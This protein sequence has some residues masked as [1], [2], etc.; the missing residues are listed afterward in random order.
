MTQF[1]DY[2]VGN[3]SENKGG[4]MTYQAHED[5]EGFE[6]LYE[7]RQRGEM[8]LEEWAAHLNPYDPDE[9]P[10]SYGP[11]REGFLLGVCWFL[12]H[13]IERHKRD[14][15]DIEADIEAIKQKHAPGIDLSRIDDFVRVR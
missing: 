12:Y 6:T 8:T 3:L 10:A 2:N 4:I 9:Q 1:D 7:T 13:E 11:C 5:A 15:R 14:I